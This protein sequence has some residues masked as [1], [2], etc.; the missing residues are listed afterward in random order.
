ML[1]DSRI[2]RLTMGLVV[3]VAAGTALAATLPVV[4]NTSGV[5]ASH[6]PAAATH[7]NGTTT[8]DSAAWWCPPIC[9]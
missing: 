2:A 4:N 5:A 3:A 6:Q 1:K 9:G 8:Q 7:I